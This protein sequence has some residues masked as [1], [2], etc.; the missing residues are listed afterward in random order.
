MTKA[1]MGELENVGACPTGEHLSH[2]HCGFIGCVD[3]R[4][5]AKANRYRYRLEESYEAENNAHVKGDG[6]WFVEVLCQRGLIY[7]AGGLDLTAYTKSVHA[8]RE[9]L[10]VEGIS[11]KQEA[12]GEWRCRFPLSQLDAV[13]AI[14]R[15]RRK[16]ATGASP[17]Q[18]RA[19]RERRKSLDQARKTLS[20]AADKPPDRG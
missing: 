3:L 15:P 16:K 11:K 8:W 20:G 9:L 6:R 17:Q 7:P 13:A 5:W 14:L 10:E 12:S 19:M 2:P 18:L 1:T 4:P